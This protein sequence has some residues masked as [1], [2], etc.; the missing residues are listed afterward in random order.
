MAEVEVYCFGLR[1][2]WLDFGFGRVHVLVAGGFL[3]ADDVLE[4][5]IVREF[6]N[7]NTMILTLFRRCRH[8][9]AL[10]QV[11]NELEVF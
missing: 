6:V 4:A 7:P 9:F 10:F 5:K 3:L 2:W 11:A 1:R 8:E